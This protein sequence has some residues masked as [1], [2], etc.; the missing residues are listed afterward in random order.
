ML[1][2]ACN[3]CTKIILKKIFKEE[4]KTFSNKTHTFAFFYFDNV[5]VVGGVPGIKLE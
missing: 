4:K 2:I 5:G 3:I 1:L